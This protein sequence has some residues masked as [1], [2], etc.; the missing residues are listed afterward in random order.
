MIDDLL[1]QTLDLIARER[2]LPESTYRVQF[3][4]GFTFRDAA[5]IVPFLHEL[6]ITDLYASPYLKA[7]P[8]SMHGY[9][10]TDHRALNPEIGSQEDYDA[11]VAVLHKL[12]MGQLLD[13]VPNQMVIHAS[14][15]PWWQ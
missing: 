12:D 15:I 14:E 11:L 4:A 6:G 7:R 2:R 9:D 10:I 5:A 1:R 13:T 3:H 8:G